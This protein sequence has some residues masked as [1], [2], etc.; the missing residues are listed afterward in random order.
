MYNT[1]IINTLVRT[2]RAMYS[3]GGIDYPELRKMVIVLTGEFDLS[4]N[5]AKMVTESAGLTYEPA[6]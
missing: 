5:H 1:T 4:D 6:D 2:M 3:D